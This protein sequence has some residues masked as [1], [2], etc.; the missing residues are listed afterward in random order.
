MIDD[1]KI[2]YLTP[3]PTKDVVEETDFP[4]L[5]VAKAAFNSPQ[6]IEHAKQRPLRDALQ[7]VFAFFP[8]ANIVRG[9]VAVDGCIVH[10]AVYSRGSY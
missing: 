6:S 5:A 8:E 9:V 1:G 2:L 3:I 4:V 10:S 7:E